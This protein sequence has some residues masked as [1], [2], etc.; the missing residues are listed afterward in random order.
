MEDDVFAAAF[1]SAATVHVDANSF[2]VTGRSE[3]LCLQY[4]CYKVHF[5]FSGGHGDAGQVKTTYRLEGA[6]A[7]ITVTS[8]TDMAQKFSQHC[9]VA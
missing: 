4:L 1:R 5:Y 9:S 2:M 8:S 6:G 3:F 7:T